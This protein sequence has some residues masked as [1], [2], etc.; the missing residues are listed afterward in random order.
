VSPKH[1]DTTPGWIKRRF[2]KIEKQLRE[3]NA[4]KRLEAATIGRGGLTIKNRGTLLSKYA[5]GATAV[6]IGPVY[7]DAPDEGSQIALLDETGQ[8]ILNAYRLPVSDLN[9]TAAS[10]LYA[11]GDFVY[12]LSKSYTSQVYIDDV[13]VSLTGGTGGVK[14]THSTTG[15][16]ANCYIDPSDGRIW[17]STS[18]RRYKQDIEDAPVDPAAVLQMQPRTWRDKAEVQADPDTGRRYIGFIA[19]ELHE[20]GLSQF[21]VYDA[22]DQPEAISYDRLSV[23]LL[24]VVKDQETRLQALEAK[25]AE[26]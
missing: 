8:V 10:A 23:A 18:S 21:V 16:S 4:A 24:A 13:V 1:S 3:S 6:L 2:E 14:I 20:L 22:D 26:A 7:P 15:A 17:R 5:T 25:A 11:Q 12:L 19:E 9:P